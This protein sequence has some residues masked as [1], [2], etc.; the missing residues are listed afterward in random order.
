[1][2]TFTKTTTFIASATLTLAFSLFAVTTVFAAPANFGG[3]NGNAWFN[4]DGQHYVNTNNPD[5]RMDWD[6]HRFA[7]PSK[8]GHHA[9]ENAAVQAHGDQTLVVPKK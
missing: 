3:G 4:D 1:M 9:D 7:I 2:T 5:L 6:N 8:A